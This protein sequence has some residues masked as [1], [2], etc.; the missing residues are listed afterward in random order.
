MKITKFII[1]IV[2]N[3]NEYPIN[4]KGVDENDVLKKLESS[5]YRYDSV[6]SVKTKEQAKIECGKTSRGYSSLIS[7]NGGRTTKRAIIG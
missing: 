2:K 1:T 6:V 7:H 3:G 5:T 4:F